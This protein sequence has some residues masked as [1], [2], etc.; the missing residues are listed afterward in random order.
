VIAINILALDL[1]KVVG[2][3]T[4]HDSFN[5]GVKDLSPKKGEST[6]MV[7]I[8][9]RA[10][11]DEMLRI[12]GAKMVIYEKPLVG[13]MRNGNVA[14]IAYGLSAIVQEVCENHKVDYTNIMP[15]ELKKHA[16]GKGNANKE[17]MLEA[18][19]AKWPDIEIIDHNHADALWLLDYAKN[20]VLAGV[21]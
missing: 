18:A 2:W 14:Q 11:L 19:K 10:W 20:V 12:S 8:R 6:G 3:A 17:K 7:F 13:T 9:F 15:A 4:K 5:S 1:A 16:T 21:G